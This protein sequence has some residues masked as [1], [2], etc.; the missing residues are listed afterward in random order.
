MTIFYCV[1]CPLL[2]KTK[3]KLESRKKVCENML[4][5]CNVVMSSEDTKILEFNQSQKYDKAPFII[6]ADLQFCI[7]KTDKGKSNPENHLQ[8]KK[9]R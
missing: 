2:F 7:E 4:W 3:S 6:Y 5:C 1:N 8:Q 9:V